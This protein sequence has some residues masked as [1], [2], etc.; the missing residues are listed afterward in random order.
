MFSFFQF[1]L[2]Y[3]LRRKKS[4]GYRLLTRRRRSYQCTAQHETKKTIDE[5]C[6]THHIFLLLA[7]FFT[8]VSYQ[9]FQKMNLLPGSGSASLPGTNC[10]S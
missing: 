2:V 4:S 1:V 3:T 8:A 5:I 6:F 10:S 7:A 9:N